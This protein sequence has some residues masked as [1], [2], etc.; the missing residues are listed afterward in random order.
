MIDAFP[1]S[2][3]ADASGEAHTPCVGVVTYGFAAP[4]VGEGESVAMDIR[5]N[6][7]P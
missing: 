5:V 2:T 1:G 4:P 6:A 7:E 3:G